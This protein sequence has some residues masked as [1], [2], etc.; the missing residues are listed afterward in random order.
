[1]M[2]AR[3]AGVPVEGICLYPIANHPG[4]DDDR[5]CYN[6]LFDY[7]DANC[8]REIY[9]PLAQEIE[10]QRKRFGQED[11]LTQVANA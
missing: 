10:K 4:W 3:E 5:H 9:Q 1:V 8:H 11:S 6:G 7:P 2:A